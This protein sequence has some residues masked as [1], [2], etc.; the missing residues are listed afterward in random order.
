[1]LDRN[2]ERTI[3]ANVAEVLIALQANLLEHKEIVAEARAGYIL[4]C[5]VA[6]AAA[7]ERILKRLA[8]LD[9][10]ASVTMEAITF[11]L[12]APQDH[13]K[14]FETVI[15]MLE[16][17]QAAW[18]D[19]PNNI[20]ADGRRIPATIQLKAQDVQR[21]VLNDW[22]WMDTFLLANSTYSR[23]SQ[24]IASDKGLI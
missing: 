19:N 1:M 12:N 9:E 11:N 7:Q 13:S 20:S 14:E 15:R 10:G 22:S 21:F 5:R 8:K 18:D 16:L 24:A 6:L 3:T 17:H 23:K 4:Q 2:D